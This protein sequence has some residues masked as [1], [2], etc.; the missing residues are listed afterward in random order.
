EIRGRHPQWGGG[1]NGGW[2][3]MRGSVEIRR[4][5]TGGAENS[6]LQYSY[7]DRG[8]GPARWFR[9]DRAAALVAFGGNL[10]WTQR[11]LLAGRPADGVLYQITAVGFGPGRGSAGG[12]GCRLGLGSA[13]LRRFGWRR[14]DS[15]PRRGRPD[16]GGG[17]GAL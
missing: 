17:S 1:G 2:L 3:L 4:L 13:G 7:V 8:T 11:H 9:G 10:A 12:P 14:S 15:F 6:G 5:G 16:R